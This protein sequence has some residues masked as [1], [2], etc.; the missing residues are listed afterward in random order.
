MAMNFKKSEKAEREKQ[1]KINDLALA[2][3]IANINDPEAL[4]K[5]KSQFKKE[6]R[7]LLKTFN[8]NDIREDMINNSVKELKRFDKY[9]TY[10]TTRLLKSRQFKEHVLNRYVASPLHKAYG[11]SYREYGKYVEDAI[12]KLKNGTPA[13]KVER[14]FKKVMKKKGINI[15]RTSS[16]RRYRA[17]RWMEMA[18]RT[19]TNKM[20]IAST[21]SYMDANNWGSVVHVSKHVGRAPRELCA[22]YEGKYINLDGD[23]GEMKTAEGN[24]ITY[25]GVGDTSYGEPAGIFGIN[26]THTAT[27]VIPNDE[28]TIE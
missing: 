14:Q 9:A 10:K 3:F 18:V 17:D 20:H 15:V 19:E 25:L 4:K 8:Y 28:Y 23:G 27:P 26:C 21:L 13:L 22:P 2:L 24:T 11:K 1:S 6:L 7:K 16:G 5:T 12:S